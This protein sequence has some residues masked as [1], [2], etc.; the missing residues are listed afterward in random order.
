MDRL[1]G[2]TGFSFNYILGT[3]RS[4]SYQRLFALNQAHGRDARATRHGGQAW[5]GH[6]AHVWG[7]LN[8]KGCWHHTTVTR[9]ISSWAI[10]AMM[11]SA[12]SW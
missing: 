7:N 12:A 9:G 3:K 8:A 4:A 6:P 2:E 5:H 10:A 11:R 1:D